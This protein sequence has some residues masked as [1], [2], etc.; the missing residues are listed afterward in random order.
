VGLNFCNGGAVPASCFLEWVKP[1]V[2]GFVNQW[3]LTCFATSNRRALSLTPIEVPR[4][5]PYS[6]Q[7][8][9]NTTT[10]TLSLAGR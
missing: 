10:T 7:G 8:R 9:Q 2:D 3:E 5:L 6:V 4:T 1:Q